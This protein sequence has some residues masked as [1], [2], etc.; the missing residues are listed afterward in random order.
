MNIDELQQAVRQCLE[1]E[2]IIPPVLGTWLR[3][4]AEHFQYE[5]VTKA[6]ALAK[7]FK[8]LTYPYAARDYW[9]LEAALAALKISDRK[10]GV[11]RKTQFVKIR[12]G[13][14]LWVKNS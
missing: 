13:I 8:P 10:A 3:K 4:A 14:E 1:G 6:Q 12:N 7:D 2:Q 11:Q 9:M 5:T